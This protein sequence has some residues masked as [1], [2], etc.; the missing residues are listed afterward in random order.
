MIPSGDSKS[1]LVTALYSN[2]VIPYLSLR[3]TLTRWF[4]V[5]TCHC[6][7]LWP[8]DS[9]SI[10]LTM[11]YSDHIHLCKLWRSTFNS[12]VSTDA[13]ARIHPQLVTFGSFLSFC[14]CSFFGQLYHIKYV[15]YLYKFMTLCIYFSFPVSNM[16][17]GSLCCPE[18]LGHNVALQPLPKE[19]QQVW[20]LSLSAI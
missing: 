9:K 20:G 12:F 4:Q 17:Q 6:G 1:I 3:C 15:L 13:P 14:T 16:G 10:L 2:Q 19:Y 8:G 7:I 18:D 11:A 5:D